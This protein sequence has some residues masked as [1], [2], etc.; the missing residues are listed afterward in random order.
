VDE[1]VYVTMVAGVIARIA[2]SSVVLFG[3]GV[4]GMLLGF[5]DRAASGRRL[6]WGGR[7]AAYGRRRPSLV[8]ML[9]G[10]GTLVA[11][12]ACFG[13]VWREP[14]RG[15]G[16]ILC[17][18]AAFYWTRRWLRE[19]TVALMQPGVGQSERSQ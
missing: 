2:F 16:S 17:A 8:A 3:A 12:Q 6:S 13:G 7:L 15:I 4:L 5:A 1:L 19:G 18:V 10:A 14:L 11:L 9:A